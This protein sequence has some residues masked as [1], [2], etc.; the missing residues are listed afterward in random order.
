MTEDNI[1]NKYLDIVDN[2]VMGQGIEA[3]NQIHDILKQKISDEIDDLK[4]EYGQTLFQE[5]GLS[6]DLDLEDDEAEVETADTVQPEA[7]YDEYSDED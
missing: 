4:Q 3:Q 6:D 1:N 7:E 2:A 5:P